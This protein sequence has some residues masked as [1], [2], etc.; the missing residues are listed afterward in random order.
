MNGFKNVYKMILAS[1]LFVLM[2]TS[3]ITNA[4]VLEDT[5]NSA[6]SHS[7]E[8][9]SAKKVLVQPKKINIARYNAFTYKKD[10]PKA[11]GV[12]INNKQV[13]YFIETEGGF[14][15]EQRAKSL[16]S[17]INLFI[18]NNGDPKTILP[19]FQD[20]IA[21]GRANNKPLFTSDSKVAESLH[22]TNAEL[23]RQWVNNIRTSL[24]APK[25]VRDN[26]LI[27]SRSGLSV[28]FSRKYTEVKKVAGK[29]QIGIASWYGGFFNG[30]KTADGSRFN[31]HKF[32]AAHKT[33]PFGSLVKVTNL[34]NSKTCVVKITDRGPYIPGRIIDLS[35]AAAKKIDMFTSGISKVK[36]EVIEIN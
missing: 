19:G 1:G 17:R 33:L 24:G 2:S 31:T 12:Y 35:A 7:L 36:L 9:L 6:Q 20:G 11:A 22:I 18:S 28:A 29:E 32:T 10:M 23:A 26:S 21:I 25:F 15:P 3:C 16:V 34:Q 13:A 14:S 8:T 27:A 30:R 5:T 4:N